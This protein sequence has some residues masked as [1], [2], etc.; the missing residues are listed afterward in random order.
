MKGFTNGPIVF[1][2]LVVFIFPSPLF[3]QE[4]PA[5]LPENLRSTFEEYTQRPTHRAFALG[6]WGT[7]YGHKSLQKAREA[8]LSNCRAYAD[9]CV[10]ISENDEIVRSEN[11]FPDPTDRDPFLSFM[12]GLSDRTVVLFALIG[13]V[14][15]VTGTFLAERYPLY[16]FD[17]GVSDALRIRMNY[18]FYPF[19]IVYFFCMFPVFARTVQGDFSNPLTWLSFSWPILLCMF[20]VLYLNWKGKLYEHFELS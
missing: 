1:A 6:A 3:G 10:V 13:I 11:P 4:G 5:Y 19:S 17:T 9:R 8:A 12:E 15:L 7:A 20:S 16:L 14:L 18:T 2:L